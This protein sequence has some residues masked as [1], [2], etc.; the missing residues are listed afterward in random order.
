VSA[1]AR[2]WEICRYASGRPPPHHGFLTV[3]A[4]SPWQLATWRPPRR[5]PL[6]PAWLDALGPRMEATYADRSGCSHF[7]S[8]EG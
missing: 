2:L 3:D 7:D 6:A 8:D 4:P 1:P 5:P